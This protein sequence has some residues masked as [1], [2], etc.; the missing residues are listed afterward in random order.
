MITN[1]LFDEVLLSPAINGCEKLCIVSGYATSAMTFHHFK[2]L[3]ED[4]DIDIEIELI[5]GMTSYDGIS[6]GNHKGFIQLVEKEFKGRLKCSYNFDNPPVHSKI[7]TW[8]KDDVPQLGFLGSANYSQRAFFGKSR[9]VLVPYDPLMTFDYFRAIETSTI[10]C[11]HN[12][13]EDNILIYSESRKNK[14]KIKDLDDLD[15]GSIDGLES[16]I[17]SFINRYGDISQRSGL[18]WGQRPEEGREPNQAYIP[19]K[20]DVYRTSFF[21]EVGRHFTVTTDDGKVL[22]C[23]RAQENGKAIHTPHNNSLIGEYFRNRLNVSYGAP[24]TMHDFE[25]YGRFDVEFQK[26]D[27]ENYYMNFS[28]N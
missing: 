1:N 26:I 20:S 4:Y 17:V 14:S 13:I 11:T 16:V 23:S 27:E 5:L 9:E 10:S 7:Y 6:I 8:V 12:E 3:L 21:P 22:I 19:L 2:K 24:V 25:K 15:F 28:A 18:N